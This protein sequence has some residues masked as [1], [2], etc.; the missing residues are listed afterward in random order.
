MGFSPTVQY[1]G[2]KW[3]ATKTC[4]SR[5]L[6]NRGAFSSSS[7][8]CSGILQSDAP[9]NRGAFNR[10]VGSVRVTLPLTSIF[11]SGLLPCERGVVRP[12]E[13]PLGRPCR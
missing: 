13:I 10:A 1:P 12:A 9:G 4:P 3:T 5:F 6:C 11:G 7:L 8:V 2:L